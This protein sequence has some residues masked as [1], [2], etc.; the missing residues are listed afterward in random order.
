MQLYKLEEIASLL[1]ELKELSDR[2]PIVFLIDE[3]DK[4]WDASEDAKA[5]VGGLFQA[6][7]S[8]NQLSNNFTVIVSLRKELYDNIPALYEDFQKYNDIFEVLEWNNKSLLK[9]ITKRISHSLPEIGSLK[10]MD[11]WR[12]ILRS[13]CVTRTLSN[14]SWKEHCI[15][16]EKLFNF[17]LNRAKEL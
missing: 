13:R 17:V 5:F 11:Y 10:Q 3:L 6:T 9:L 12:T 4:G 16:Q 7:I 1:P 15:D 8:I 2:R 14:I